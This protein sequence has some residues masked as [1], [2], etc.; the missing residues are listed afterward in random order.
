MENGTC[1]KMVFYF[2]HS[3]GVGILNS[4]IFNSFHNWVQ[5][6]M[7]L[8]GLRNFGGGV[9]TPPPVCHWLSGLISDPVPGRFKSEE[10]SYVL[11]FWSSVAFAV[12]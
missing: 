10:L 4:A 2:C 9:N 12:W 6:G 8:E 3:G 1:K 11:G 7:I 5:F